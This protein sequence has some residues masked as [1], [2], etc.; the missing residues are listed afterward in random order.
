MADYVLSEAAEN[1]LREI[2][3]YTNDN[4]GALQ[5]E[6]YH[7]AFHRTFGLLADFPLMGRSA[8][9]LHQGLRQM[10]QG[11]HMIFYTIREDRVHIEQ[12]FHTKQLMRR[13]MFDD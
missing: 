3:L 10:Q 4:F 12:I 7:E 11:S 5:A 2:Y 8:D 1:T 9:E 13:H 6:A